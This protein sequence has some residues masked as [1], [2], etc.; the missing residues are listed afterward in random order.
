MIC[1]T[2][3]TIDR[4]ESLK[5]AVFLDRDGTLTE[6]RGFITKPSQIQLAENAC[7]SLQSLRS[8][9]FAIVLIT[10]QS[11]IG[12]GMITHDQLHEIHSELTAQLTTGNAQLD[13]IYYCPEAPIGSDETI[14]E[15]PNRKPGPGMLLAAARDLNLDLPRSWMIGDRVSDILA[16]QNAGCRGNILINSDRLTSD[17]EL[18]SDYETRNTLVEAAA[19]ILNSC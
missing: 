18:S 4:Y 11:A 7:E 2:H 16:G 9:G 8:A 14:I 15:S 17:C 6:Y 19:I 5:P 10:N 3:R 12:R 13:A 1:C